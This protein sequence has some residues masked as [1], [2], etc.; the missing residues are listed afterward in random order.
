[1]VSWSGLWIQKINPG[2]PN[3]LSSQYLKKDV[4]LIFF[5]KLCFYQSF[6]LSLNLLSLSGHIEST[7]T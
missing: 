6:R 5:I 1:M 2:Q 7:L 3:M 4:V